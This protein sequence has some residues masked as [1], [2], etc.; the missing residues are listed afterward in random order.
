MSLIPV[1]GL[2][3]HAEL[4]TET[5]IF[6]SC[7]NKFGEKPNT[8]VCP[9]CSGM[10]G[11]LPT[12]N[13][14]AFLLAVKA[15]L[16]F[17]CKINN[18]S[19]FD[20]KNYFYPDLPKGYQITQYYHPLCENGFIALNNKKFNIERIHLEEDAG[21]LIHKNN[22]TIIDLNR[23]G[24]PLIEIVTKPDFRSAEEVCLFIREI[25]ARLKYAEICDAR[26][27]EGSL[28]VDVNISV[29]DENSS[30]LGTRAEI[31][32]LNSLKSVTK[33]IEY[34]F[35][36]QCSLISKGEK[37]LPETRRYNE[38]TGKTT[39]MRIKEKPSDYR[40]FPEPDLPKI[41]IS[42]QKINEIKTAL[43]EMPQVRIS[44]YISEYGISECDAVLLTNDRAVSD[45]FEACLLIYMSPKTTAKIILGDIFRNMNEQKLK[46]IPL[47]PK[48]V[49]ECAKLLDDKQITGNALSE[50]VK[51]MFEKEEAP[52]K[53]AVKNNFLIKENKAEIERIVIEVLSSNKKAVDEYNGGK[54][55]AFA[56]LMGQA[57]RNC[58]KG[59][60]PKTVT[61]ILE[62]ILP[63]FSRNG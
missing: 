19:S 10:P 6:C 27:E 53:I 41:Y 42:E 33:A 12:L 31:K 4:L 14:E 18:K 39:A 36:R 21:K 37:I 20:R 59:T 25:S 3:I 8:L 34:E 28:R 24:V 23:C 45:F 49:A 55:K 63:T 32:N 44:R 35:N 9:V 2:E 50:I 51:I 7:A 61:E 40:Y 13:K 30:V 15:G 43:P 16:V 5:K 22:S 11:T 58:E 56:F 1:I 54:K 29:R 17:Y 48:N 52:Y 47:L 46:K 62:N 38:N 60:N 57:M 26:L